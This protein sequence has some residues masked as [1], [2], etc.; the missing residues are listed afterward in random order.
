MFDD[1]AKEDIIKALQ[2]SEMDL[3]CTTEGKDLKVK[4][5]TTKREHI[6]AALKQVKQCLD[7]FKRNVKQVRHEM[8]NVVKK[9]DKI[10]PQEDLKLFQK[11][12][13]KLCVARET[14]AK[15]LLEAKEKEIKGV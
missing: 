5:G 15:K 2:R 10:M 4:L 13:E 11:D 7:E 12:L 8:N 6:E 14:E 9:L 3:N 1:N